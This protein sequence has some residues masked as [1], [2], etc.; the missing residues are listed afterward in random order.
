MAKTSATISVG[1]DTRQLERDIQSA[2]A[3]DFKFKGFSEKAFTQ[4]LGRITGAANE[5]QKSLDA[6]NARV[7]A[8]GASAGLIYSVEKAFTS[9]VKSTID[10]QK[11]LTDINVI[12]NTNSANLQRFG[13][14]LFDIAKNTAQSFDTVAQAATEFARQGLTLEETLK[15]TKDALILTRLS[16]LDTISSVEALTATLNSFNKAGLDSTAVINKLANVDAAFAV[17]S[18]DLAEAIKRVGSSATD[19]GVSFDQLL[20]IVTSVQQTTARGGAVI[21]NSL[22]TIFT[23]L[24]RTSVL[25]QLERLGIQVRDTQDNTLPAIQIL[26]NLAKTYDTLG[27]AQKSQTAELVGGVFQ[28]NILKA[29][30][31]DL[32]KQYS[33]YKN[34]LDTAG[35]STDEA[36]IRNEKLNQT[37]SALVNKTFVNLT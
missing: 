37:L 19:A 4:P 12:L 32:N 20:A 11:S 18:G 6:S 3:R 2:L 16:G 24:E 7:I 34:A 5:F 23:R 28:I 1:A 26:S 27:D 29:A 35:S 36:I 10:V 31:G 15:R 21:G 25:D 13:N 14:S 30:L 17:S 22:K 9:L 8:F 33:V